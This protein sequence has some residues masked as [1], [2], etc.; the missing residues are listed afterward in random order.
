MFHD[1]AFRVFASSGLCSPAEDAIAESVLGTHGA[2]GARV[3]TA[4]RVEWKRV[5]GLELALE[6]LSEE[7][8]V[9]AIAGVA[10]G[11][12][13]HSCLIDEYRQL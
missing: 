9:G 7:R 4:V 11:T 6:R 13:R 1:D 3:V 2:I 8:H 5:E 12:E 10:A